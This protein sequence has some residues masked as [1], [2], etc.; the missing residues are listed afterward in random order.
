MSAQAA[1]RY[2]KALMEMAFE[3]KNLETVKVDILLIRDVLKN[4]KDLR[5]FLQS[6]VIRKEQKLSAL[7]S[8]FKDKVSDLTFSFINLLSEK[9]REKIL[10]DI[11]GHFIEQYNHHHGIIEVGVTS[12]KGL[13]SGQLEK[14]KAELESVTGKSVN[15]H[16]SVNDALIG[17]LMVRID[18]TVIDGS[19]KFKLN[20]LKDR[21]TSSAVE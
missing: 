20:Q 16:S 11:T 2:A 10:E 19:V 5:L 3:K 12:A 15:L 6:P 8:I 4:S 21:L 17:G 1:R 7:Q 13:D 9:S 14:L 18:D